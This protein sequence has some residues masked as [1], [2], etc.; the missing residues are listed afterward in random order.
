[1]SIIDSIFPAPRA[2]IHSITGE[3]VNLFWPVMDR[4]V[5]RYFNLY[6]ADFENGPYTIYKEKISNYDGGVRSGFPGNIFQHIIRAEVVG[7]D[8]EHHKYAKVT[9]VNASGAE[10]ALGDSKSIYLAPYNT[11][12]TYWDTNGGNMYRSF[13]ETISYNTDFDENVFEIRRMLGKEARSIF[14]EATSQIKVRFN[15]IS[16]DTITI[17]SGE[18]HKFDNGEVEVW[19]MYV[20]NKDGT[21]PVSSNIKVIVTT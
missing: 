12:Q 8:S 19:R 6:L 7:F 11:V 16:A 17:P 14:I 18:A 9:Y 21:Y 15:Y 13:E 4:D 20:S 5:V 10:S 3:Q 1:M 2:N